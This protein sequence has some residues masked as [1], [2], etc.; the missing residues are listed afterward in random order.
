MQLKSLDEELHRKERELSSV[1][2]S[3][4]DQTEALSRDAAAATSKTLALAEASAALQ[5]SSSQ[6]V[7]WLSS[8]CNHVL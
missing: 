2:A 7:F 1:R 5:V 8:L 6:V 4:A 3:V